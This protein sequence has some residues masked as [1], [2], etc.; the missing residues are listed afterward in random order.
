M[1][2]RTMEMQFIL[3]IHLVQLVFGQTEVGEPVDELR[4]KH[5]GLAVERITGEPDQLF[6]AEADFAGVIELGTQ[7]ALVDDLGKPYMPAA[8]DDREGSVLFR[9]EL[10][11]HL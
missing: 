11:D 7:L 8:V 4:R 5:L 9:I 2:P 10:P 1:G 3:A 6:L